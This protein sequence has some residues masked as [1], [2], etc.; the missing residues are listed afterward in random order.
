MSDPSVDVLESRA[1]ATRT[2]LCG[3]LQ[4]QP[5]ACDTKTTLLLAYVDIAFE[6]HEAIALLIR[7]NLH[8]SAFALTRPLFETMFKALWINA[9][10]TSDQVTRA[11]KTGNNTFPRTGEMIALVDQAYSTDGFFTSIK[12]ASWKAM[13]SYAHSGLLQVARRFSGDHVTP[14]YSE[15][16]VRAVLN[17][18]TTAIILLARMFLVSTKCHDEAA[19]VQKLLE[20]FATA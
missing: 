20:Q 1:S 13:C 10:A 11:T 15:A 4:K 19:H 16:E 12:N 7:S 18:T 17:A 2:K 8:G 6:H 3:L 14:N 5:Y 9:C